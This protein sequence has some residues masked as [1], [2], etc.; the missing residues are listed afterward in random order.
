MN[1]VKKVKKSGEKAI[2]LTYDSKVVCNAVASL[3]LLLHFKY[4]LYI[5]FVKRIESKDNFVNFLYQPLCTPQQ[6][7]KV[8]KLLV[9]FAQL[10][11]WGIICRP[12]DHSIYLYTIDLLKQASYYLLYVTK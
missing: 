4:I 3:Y 5:I 8:I 2:L 9:S 7:K 1:S 6:R 11:Y 12:A 10:L